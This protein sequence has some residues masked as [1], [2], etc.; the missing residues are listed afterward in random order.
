[1]EQRI[2]IRKILVLISL[3]LGAFT[4]SA[5]AHAVGGAVPQ[6]T[7]ESWADAFA[8]RKRPDK[9]LSQMD[10]ISVFVTLRTRDC[11]QNGRDF[12]ERRLEVVVRSQNADLMGEPLI[13]ETETLANNDEIFKRANPMTLTSPSQAHF[14]FHNVSSRA[15]VGFTNKAIIYRVLKGTEELAAIAYED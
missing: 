12:V 13:L 4:Y 2:R 10:H 6:S 1:M 15:P 11:E 14:I 9:I 8:A 3:V 7:C 5:S